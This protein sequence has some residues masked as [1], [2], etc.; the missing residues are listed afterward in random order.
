[1]KNIFYL[2]IGV[3]LLMVSCQKID[4]WDEP[5]S[6]LYGNVIDTY[7][8]T[9]LAMDQNDWQI[10]IIDRDWEKK[11]NSVSQ[12]QSLAV[13]KD[14]VYNNSKLFPST[15]D[16]IPYDGP[17]WPVDTVKG[18]VLEKETQQDFKVTPYLQV[19]NFTA[20]LT[21][22]SLTLNCTV[23]APLLMN[24]TVALPNLYEVKP[25][26]SLTTFCGNSNYINIAEYN[27]LRKQINRTWAAELANL[28]LPANSDAISY[29]MGPLPVKSGYTYYV[30]VGANVN[31]L[32]RR[33]NYSPIVKV[34]VP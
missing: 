18:V 4:N 25:F 20:T 32:S 30:R 27:N 33:Y 6:R 31:A 7:T 29:T 10:R 13:M 12:F 11:N 5:G 8:G 28:K 14:G 2:M 23:K 26:L 24:G 17:F 21:G 34:V 16:M 3:A 19:L 15:Y 1:M 22:T 9:N